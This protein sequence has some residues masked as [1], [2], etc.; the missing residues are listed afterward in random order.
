MRAESVERPREVGLDRDAD[1]AAC[2]DDAEED[3]GAMGALCAAGKEHVEAEP[4]DVLK[5]ALGRV[6]VDGHLGVADEAEQRTASM[7]GSDGSSVGRT[8][9]SD[10]P[11]RSWTS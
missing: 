6:V 3:A 9:L 4:G 11:P 2:R 5:L 7:S 8:A 10:L 1:C